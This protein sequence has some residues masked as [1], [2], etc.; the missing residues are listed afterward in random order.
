MWFHFFAWIPE[1]MPRRDFSNP[2]M[3]TFTMIL[4]HARP[5][6]HLKRQWHR[7]ISRLPDD[8]PPIPI[9]TRNF[10]KEDIY[11]TEKE[12]IKSNRCSV[13]RG[14]RYTHPVSFIRSSGGIKSTFE[15]S[16][17]NF[18]IKSEAIKKEVCHIMN[19][20]QLKIMCW[21]NV[22]IKSQVWKHRF[23]NKIPIVICETS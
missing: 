14:Q 23:G 9:T 19:T 15:K 16:F 18:Y 10:K 3:N 22:F 12:N 8:E 20:S 7:V 13:F 11:S 4:L 21:K 6:D 17:E 1:Q 2:G 5:P